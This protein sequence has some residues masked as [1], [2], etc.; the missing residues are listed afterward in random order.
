MQAVQPVQQST[1]KAN[2]VI[3]KNMSMADWS[4]SRQARAASRQ[5]VKYFESSEDEDEEDEE[6]EGQTEGANP[7]IANKNAKT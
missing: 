6:D 5:T 1:Q 2:N 7:T 4:N 3:D